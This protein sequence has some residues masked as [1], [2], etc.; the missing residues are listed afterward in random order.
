M[1]CS[2]SHSHSRSPAWSRSTR[3]G[4]CYDDQ[5]RQVNYEHEC[6]YEHDYSDYRQSVYS[7]YYRN[8][9]EDQFTDY[10]D[11][12]STSLNKSPEYEQQ[13]SGHRFSS[14]RDYPRSNSPVSY[15]HSC[16]SRSPV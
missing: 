10:K 12:S 11:Y 8:E 16:R 5:S 6:D 14:G 4:P 1:D 2:R 15:S 9:Y 3:Q 7:S 13:Y